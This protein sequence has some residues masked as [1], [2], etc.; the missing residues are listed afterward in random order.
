MPTREKAKHISNCLVLAM[1]LEVNTSKPGNVTPTASF[2]GTRIEHFLASAVASTSSFEEAAQRGVAVSENKLNIR[3]V[4]I[5]EI[6][7]KC[8]VDITAWQTG[9]NTLL[10][11]VLLLVPLAV[12]A[13]MT[14]TGENFSF[15]FPV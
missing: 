9:G 7:K 5:G 14:P 13:G 3:E 4:G 8:A 15:N 6:I 2:E 11:T 1:L 12:A 10:G